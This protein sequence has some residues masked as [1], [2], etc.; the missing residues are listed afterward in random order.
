MLLGWIV[1]RSVGRSVG[2]LLKAALLFRLVFLF[3]Y[4]APS[5]RALAY[6]I[7]EANLSSHSPRFRSLNTAIGEMLDEY[8]LVSFIPIR[9]VRPVC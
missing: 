4:V 3:R 1:G 9:S 8:S 7:H 6:D 5:G 2:G